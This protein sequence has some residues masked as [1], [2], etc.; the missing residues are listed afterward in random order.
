[1]LGGADDRCAIFPWFRRS[2]SGLSRMPDKQLPAIALLVFV[3]SAWCAP[4]FANYEVCNKSTRATINLA[5]ATQSDT[6]LNRQHTLIGW[7]VIP[8]GGCATLAT[9]D[10]SDRGF[11][12]H[13]LANGVT[14]TSEYANNGGPSTK[15]FCVTDRAFNERY[16]LPVAS[17]SACPAGSRLAT[18]AIHHHSMWD[19]H[20][21][22]LRADGIEA[23][24]PKRANRGQEYM[25]SKFGALASDASSQLYQATLYSVASSARDSA[26]DACRRHSPAPDSCAVVLEFAD[27][28]AV[29]MRGDKEPIYLA[30]AN[31][32]ATKASASNW[33]MQRCRARGN[34]QCHERAL[35]C[36]T[37]DEDLAVTRQRQVDAEMKVIDSM[38]ELLRK[39]N[40]R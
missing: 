33:A 20:G 30:V 4:A 18:F 39:F 15:Q 25:P 36:A 7:K 2:P 8:P 11:W 26:L 27:Q 5:F 22:E 37:N 28:C 12:L 32:T 16:V 31:R 23:R 13:A 14:L 19:D 1:M 3:L 35:L 24:A 29:V 10:V 40:S 17:E 34:S 6:A 9:G 21:I 38:G